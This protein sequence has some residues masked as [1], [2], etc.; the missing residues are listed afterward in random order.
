MHRVLSA[1]IAALA[2][3]AAQGA[4]AQ[5]SASD[6]QRLSLKGGIG[7]TVEPDSFLLGFEFDQP[8]QTQVSL[9]GRLELGVDDDIVLVSPSLSARYWFD[10]SRTNLGGLRPL[11]PFV[12]AGLGFSY[13]AWDHR[14]DTVGFL[15][16]L[17]FGAEWPLTPAVAVG[18]DMRF[19]II[20]AGAGRE[21][22]YFAWEV[23]GVRYRF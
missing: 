11:R 16:P 17:G 10:L 3:S 19:N 13:L 12:N 5:F 18:S 1:S 6:S 7:F 23:L 20:P 8:L 2:L 9:V 22:F 4:D 14:D 21:S 15:I